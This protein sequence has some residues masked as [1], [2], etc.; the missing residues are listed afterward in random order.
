MRQFCV[1]LNVLSVCLIGFFISVY[2]PSVSAQSY[3]F[4]TI[5]DPNAAGSPPLTVAAG[6]NDLGVVVGRYRHPPSS[7]PMSAFQYS[8]GNFST[9]DFPGACCGNEAL[10]INNSGVVVGDYNDNVFIHGYILANGNYST[11]DFP[12]AVV[13]IPF[14]INN[15]G[16]IVGQYQNADFSFHGFIYNGQFTTFDC[17]SGGAAIAAIN[18]QGDKVENCSNSAF[19]ITA[20]GQI[21]SISFPGAYSTLVN[22]INN[23]GQILG[24]Y[25]NLSD[26]IFNPF[27]RHAYLFSNG[28]YQTID[29]PGSMNTFAG[30]I[31]NLGQIV[32]QYEDTSQVFHGF[33]ATQAEL[34]DPVP[35]LLSGN[36][37]VAI[38]SPG[39]PQI[40]ADLGQ[41]VQGV[42][43]DGVTEVVVRIPAVNVGD[44]FTLKIFND[45]NEQSTSAD[46]DGALGNPGDTT[47]SQPQV[48]VTAV[49]T[50]FDANNP[51]PMVFAVYR[52]PIDFARPISSGG[53]KAGVCNNA[54]L[55]DDQATCRT[56]MITAQN[57]STGQN[58]NIPVSILRPPVLL[59]HGLWA[60]WQSWNNFK[61]LV[62]DDGTVDSRF[63]VGRVNYDN[64][65]GDS[66][67]AT[68][69]FFSPSQR[70]K[71]SSNSL[72]FAYNAPRVQEQIEHWIQNFKTG[73]NPLS[74]TVA[75]VQADIVGHSLGGVI[76]RTIAGQATFLSSNTFGE[77][78]IHKLITIDT[79]HLGSPVPIQLLSSAEHNGCLQN[80]LAFFNSFPLN[81][82][83]FHNG[84]TRN[85]A[86]ADLEGDDTT[87]F[88]SDALRTLN[89]SDSGP[90]HP[91]PTA[92]IAGIYEDF[93]ALDISGRAA[94][95]RGFCSMDPLAQQ[96]TSTAWPTIF[97]SHSSDAIVSQT[98]QLAGLDPS[99]GFTFV[100]FVHSH[101]I[102]ELGFSDPSVLDAGSVPGRVIFL[103][104]QPWT[105]PSLFNLLSP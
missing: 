24:T 33:L 103:L 59:I 56:V 105:T 27:P 7:D 73:Q 20:A 67:D 57:Q 82:V 52:A 85:G 58:T 50:T 9:I 97:H 99:L 15:H 47:F 37:V 25:F 66:I 96:L 26:N 28:N 94:I 61:P 60:S 40:L 32:G 1:R 80:F 55:T 48:T 70:K 71:I 19:K 100:G 98:S 34:V 89:P 8:D 90:A 16:T 76:A 21:T 11:L 3:V 81:L 64:K 91:L 54:S 75:D 69:P 12:G 77:G 42:A 74:I 78:D 22:S 102:T 101:G 68:D 95:V 93:G 46:E 39:A 36:T 38:T 44:Q 62:T 6:I 53:Y 87:G 72:G 4:K 23:S 104:N 10:G 63:S 2:A 14:A 65:I 88:L 35:D 92:L 43:A 45:Q 31:N 79:P 49:A 86:I 84:P 18:D 83:F 29:F 17:P 51:N 5:D 30:T 41:A 13:T